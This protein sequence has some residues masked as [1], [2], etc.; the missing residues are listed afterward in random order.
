MNYTERKFSI[1]ERLQRR[2]LIGERVDSTLFSDF[3]DKSYSLFKK[4]M[5]AHFGCVNAVEFSNDG[6]IFVS[7]KFLL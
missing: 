6:T 5:L 2:S 1:V 7:G 3:C 4:D